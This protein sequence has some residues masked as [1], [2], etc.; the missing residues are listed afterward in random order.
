MAATNLINAGLD[1]LKTGLA[2]FVE[3]TLA[4][5][6]AGQGNWFDLVNARRGRTERLV[7]NRDGTVYWT[8]DNI[9]NLIVIGEWDAFKAAWEPRTRRPPPPGRAI[10]DYVVKG[11]LEEIAETRRR[12]MHQEPISDRHIDR[13]LDTCQLV[14]EAVPDADSAKKI[15]DIRFLADQIYPNAKAIFDFKLAKRDVLTRAAKDY[16]RGIDETA[17]FPLV[18]RPE[19]LPSKP[20]P[21]SAFDH[22]F[23]R[24]WL[25]RNPEDRASIRLGLFGGRTCSEWSRLMKP[26]IQVTPGFCYRLA[27]IEIAD[28]NESGVALM[29]QASNYVA[30]YDTCEALAFE[31]AEWCFKNPNKSPNSSNNDLPQ[32]GASARIYD[33]SS[34]N[35]VPGLNALVILLNGPEGHQILMHDRSSPQIAEAQNTFHVVPAGTFQPDSFADTNHQRDFSMQRTILREL[36]EELLGKKEVENHTKR[37]EDFLTDPKLNRFVAGIEN[38]DVRLFFMGLG[39]DPVTTKPEVLLAIVADARRLGITDLST[40]FQNNWEGEFFTLPWSQER[41]QDFREDSQ[42]LPAA[43]ACLARAIDFFDSLSA[44]L[45]RQP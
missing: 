5:H 29:F 9:V 13:F 35:A 38:G 3:K 20:I 34:R 2:P 23:A 16:Y 15:G 22:E 18:S 39:F 17:D 32:R 19:W 41:L 7:K 42:T 26:V 36:A 44:S 37:G 10:G 1:V 40:V 45:N 25:G 43:S 30:Y 31:L 33:L 28:A 12:A 8:P 24:E 11:W 4:K 27:N 6:Y 14:L 21:L